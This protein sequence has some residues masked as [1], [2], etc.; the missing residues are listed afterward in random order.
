MLLFR[1]FKFFFCDFMQKFENLKKTSDPD[2]SDP[3]P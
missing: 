3:V 2:A 1:Y